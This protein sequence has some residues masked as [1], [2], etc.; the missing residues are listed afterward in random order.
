MRIQAL[1]NYDNV[2][3]GTVYDAPDGQA[4][5]LIA[6]GLAK[7]WTASDNKKA[8]QG[9][10]PSNP[11]GDG[12]EGR[13]S[14]ASQAAPASADPTAQPYPGGGLVTPD[15]RFTGAPE[16]SAARAPRKAAAKKAAAPRNKQRQPAE[17]K[18]GE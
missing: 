12:G 14:S 17:N 4:Q 6:K 1:D 13:P 8:P 11:T 16:A 7:A 10:D 15:P 3:E 9:D 18:G 2:Q 5:K